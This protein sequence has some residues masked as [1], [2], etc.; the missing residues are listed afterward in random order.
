M[1]SSGLSVPDVEVR[2]LYNRY[3]WNLLADQ[4]P[5]G[6]PSTLQTNRMDYAGLS[7]PSRRP[8]SS[9]SDLSDRSWRSVTLQTICRP[10]AEVRQLHKPCMDNSGLSDPSRGS[11]SSTNEIYGLPWPHRPLV[12][13]R[14]TIRMDYTGLSDPSRRS[15]ITITDLYG[16][17]WPVRPLVE[18]RQLYKRVAWISWP[19]QPLAGVRQLYKRFEWIGLACPTP[20]KIKARKSSYAATP[21]TRL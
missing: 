7:D 5:R 17:H 20:R 9:T 11:V 18:D 10:L 14:Q 15:P 21:P 16:F 19:V 1:G 4:T 8:V 12:E 6:G 13:V 2:Q 3:V